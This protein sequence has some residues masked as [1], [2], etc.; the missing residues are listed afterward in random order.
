MFNSSTTADCNTKLSA[1]TVTLGEVTCSG[2]KFYYEPNTT[3][4]QRSTD[5]A[6]ESWGCAR[7]HFT[8]VG[9]SNMS[10][11]IWFMG[12]GDS[13]ETKIIEFSGMDSTNLGPGG[14]SG[15]DSFSWNTYSNQQE[16]SSSG[17]VSG[18]YE[19][20]IHITN[21]TPV[22]C[23]DIGFGD[24]PTPSASGKGVSFQYFREWMVTIGL[25]GLLAFG[26]A[27]F[28]GRKYA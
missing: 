3:E 1:A 5:W 4:Y 15:Y 27:T 2:D 9:T 26:I 13:E 17:T 22:S 18:R 6:N 21:G 11:T 10:A 20:N 19:D 8:G 14:T 16:S 28:P 7:G 25:L 24:T 23:A 12:E